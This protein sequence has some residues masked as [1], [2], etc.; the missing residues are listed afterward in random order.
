[1]GARICKAAVIRCV[2]DPDLRFRED[3]LRMLRAGAFSAQLGFRIEAG[4]ARAIQKKANLCRALSKER[5]CA[6]TE[7]TLLSERPETLG[8]MI[9]EGLLAACAL[10][11][12]Y[13]LRQL[14][15]VP[16]G[17]GQH[18]GRCCRF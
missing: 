8:I 1:M 5:V 2:G 17:A 7:K 15:T 14:R 13:D 12:S 11:G 4:T 10:E 6:E 9:E 16:P 3:A 18:A